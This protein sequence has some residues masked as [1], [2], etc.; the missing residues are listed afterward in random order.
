MRLRQRPEIFYSAFAQHLYENPYYFILFDSTSII[1]PVKGL[2]QDF[3]KAVELKKKKHIHQKVALI[4][5]TGETS[6][7]PVYD[8]MINSDRFHIYPQIFVTQSNKISDNNLPGKRLAFK[9][10]VRKMKL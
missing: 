10:A 6:L 3:R 4:R 9:S 7:S 5:D 1:A 8:N 2:M